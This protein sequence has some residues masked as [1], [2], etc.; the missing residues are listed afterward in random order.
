M[1]I[2]A[3]INDALVYGGR[4]YVAA[5]NKKLLV[6][7]PDTVSA[8]EEYDIPESVV[9]LT[10]CGGAVY[11]ADRYGSLLRIRMGSAPDALGR[12]TQGDNVVDMSTRLL[13]LD[14]GRIAFVSMQRSAVLRTG[15][16]HRDARLIGTMR[17]KNGLHLLWSG[18][19]DFTAVLS[20][21][22][23]Y[24][25]PYP[26]YLTQGHN[27]NEKNNLKAACSDHVLVYEDNGQGLR[28]RA[29]EGERLLPEAGISEMGGL[30][31]ELLY[32]PETESFQATT[33]KAQFWEMS[34]QGEVIVRLDLPR[35]ESNLYLL[36]PCGTRSAVLSRRVRVWEDRAASAYIIDV[37]SMIEDGR[38]LWTRELSRRA[39]TVTGL[40]YD[41]KTEELLLFYSADRMEHVSPQTGE[42]T[43]AYRFPQVNFV[44]GA[45][46]Q[47]GVLFSVDGEGASSRLT[48]RSTRSGVA[49]FLPS[50]RRVR[51]ITEGPAGIVVQEGDERLYLVGLM[52]NT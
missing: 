36:C 32:V 20:G 7:D 45:A 14:D 44:Q 25:A 47:G 9:S 28:F 3:R 10:L 6:I 11:G 5:E 12:I 42:I 18:E 38:I 16:V 37:L 30:I 51:R 26:R 34:E 27:L 22:E 50:Q 52:T 15:N 1:P 17:G 19:K 33:H 48:A 21:G 29:P 13:A 35:S 24:T 43:E 46:V 41:R 23:R 40:L 49:A 31:C 2:S 39:D 4:I 8:S